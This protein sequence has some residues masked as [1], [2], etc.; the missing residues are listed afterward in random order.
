MSY[1][2]LFKICNIDWR[3]IFPDY[4]DPEDVCAALPLPAA[5]GPQ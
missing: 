3:E 5:G 1:W 2:K 4:L